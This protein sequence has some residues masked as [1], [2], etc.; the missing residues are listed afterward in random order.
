MSPLVEGDYFAPLA[1]TWWVSVVAEGL[2]LNVGGCG[3][4]GRFP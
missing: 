3:R 2:V 1:M 4:N